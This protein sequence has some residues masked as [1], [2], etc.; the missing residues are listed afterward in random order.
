[1]SII[2]GVIKANNYMRTVKL[3]VVF[4]S[5]VV[6]TVNVGSI[7]DGMEYAIGQFVTTCIVVNSMEEKKEE[8]K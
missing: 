4:K 2:T 7:C 1:M 5:L 6:F 8:R 3:H